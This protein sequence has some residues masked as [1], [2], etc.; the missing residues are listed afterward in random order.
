MIEK[1]SIQLIYFLC[2]NEIEG[3]YQY[4]V[5]QLIQQIQMVIFISLQLI[6][7]IQFW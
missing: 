4:L 1:I 2:F 7:K 6:K 3:D 5:E